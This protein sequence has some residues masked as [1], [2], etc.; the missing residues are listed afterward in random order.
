MGRTRNIANLVSKDLISIDTSGNIGIGTQTPTEKLDVVGVVTST[1]VGTDNFNGGVTSTNLTS[2]LNTTGIVT[3]TGLFYGGGSSIAG[4]G[5]TTF[6]SIQHR[7][8]SNGGN[9]SSGAW[10]VRD[11]TEIVDDPDGIVTLDTSTS[12]FT[13][14]P[15]R[16]VM[17]HQQT[18]LRSHFIKSAILDVGASV[19]YETNSQWSQ[20]GSF[21]GDAVTTGIT[22]VLTISSGTADFQLV[23]NGYLGYNYD[24]IMGASNGFYTD[25]NVYANAYILKGNL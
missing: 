21:Y 22:P 24:Y 11:L 17:L 2:N 13:L 18:F 25:G 19:V 9:A 12:T 6:A 14:G 7:S 23:L 8:G 15:G 3:T 4:I 16:Y 10:R 1:S 5:Y 20:R